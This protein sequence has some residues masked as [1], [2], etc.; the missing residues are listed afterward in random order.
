MS[1]DYIERK[2]FVIYCHWEDM[3]KALSDE[4]KG[5]FL[6]ALINYEKYGELPMNDTKVEMAFSL[7]KEKLDTDIVSYQIRC[8]TNAK[9]GKKGGRPRIKTQ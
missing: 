6:M 9:N 3:L 1:K 4:E 8:D 2:S 5:R 7:I